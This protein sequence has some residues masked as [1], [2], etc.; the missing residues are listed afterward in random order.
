MLVI[1]AK[2]VLCEAGT[3]F[4]YEIQIKVALQRV[5]THISIQ[6]CTVFED[7]YREVYTT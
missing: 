7:S 5:R 4:L 6:K 1:D 3:E 2:F